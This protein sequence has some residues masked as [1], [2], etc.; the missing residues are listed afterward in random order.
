MYFTIHR[1][2][3]EEN[4]KSIDASNQLV[5]SSEANLILR[6]RPLVSIS[7]AFDWGTERSLSFPESPIKPVLLQ[8]LPNM[9][10]SQEGIAS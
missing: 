1:A 8:Q 7:P 6:G 10:T 3:E 2:R 4:E 9:P 5:Q